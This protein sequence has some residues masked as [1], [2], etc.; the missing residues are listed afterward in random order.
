MLC[1]NLHST[2]IAKYDYIVRRIIYS[3]KFIDFTF[4][5]LILLIRFFL[6]VAE[7]HYQ[8]I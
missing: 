6:C 8:L 5:I 4:D 7:N 1:N 2:W 3:M